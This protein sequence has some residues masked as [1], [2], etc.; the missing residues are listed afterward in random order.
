MQKRNYWEDLS[1]MLRSV[2]RHLKPSKW[3][4]E[5]NNFCLFKIEPLI[6]F[7]GPCLTSQK[8]EKNTS[9]IRIPILTIYWHHLIPPRAL[10]QQKIEVVDMVR[11]AFVTRLKGDKSHFYVKVLCQ[12]ALHFSAHNCFQP[13][14]FCKLKICSYVLLSGLILII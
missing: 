10:Q 4:Q 1:N 12:A 5:M 6:Y 11:Y 9:S 8:G 3:F 14:I 7:A 13:N 2:K